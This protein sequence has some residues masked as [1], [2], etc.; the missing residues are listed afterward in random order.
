MFLS[1]LKALLSNHDARTSCNSPLLSTPSD[2]HTVVIM[3]VAAA[4]I[5]EGYALARPV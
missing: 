3:K 1:H 4:L 5:L 2:D